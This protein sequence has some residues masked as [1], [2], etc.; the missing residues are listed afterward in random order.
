MERQNYSLIWTIAWCVLSAGASGAFTLYAM[1]KSE[2]TSGN[3]ILSEI[4]A[5][6]VSIESQNTIFQSQINSITGTMA[7]RREIRN[8]QLKSLSDRISDTEGRIRPLEQ[9]VATLPA[10]DRRITE[11]LANINEGQTDIRQRLDRIEDKQ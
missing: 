1:G 10:M 4:A 5:L 11:G 6:K 9:I 2:G 7:D 8:D 3:Q